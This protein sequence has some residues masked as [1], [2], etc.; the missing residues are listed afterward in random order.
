MGLLREGPSPSW[1]NVSRMRY[2]LFDYLQDCTTEAYNKSFERFT[3]ALLVAFKTGVDTSRLSEKS[4]KELDSIYEQANKKLLALSTMSDDAV[5]ALY[6]KT[7]PDR[8]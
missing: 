3:A 5:R 6:R 7:F 1:E 2:E 8:L 4:E